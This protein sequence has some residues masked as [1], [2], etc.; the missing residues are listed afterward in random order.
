MAA[1][2]TPVGPGIEVTQAS[3]ALTSTPYAAA[4][5]A[6]SELYA[7]DI[8]AAR[9]GAE[10]HR[11]KSK[12]IAMRALATKARLKKDG[13]YA[14][15]QAASLKADDAA[16][17]KAK[18]LLAVEMKLD[19]VLKTRG[20]D[21][22]SEVSKSG[23]LLSPLSFSLQRYAVMVRRALKSS[24]PRITGLAD[25]NACAGDV[26]FERVLPR[27]FRAVIGEDTRDATAAIA[28]LQAQLR[29][30]SEFDAARFERTLV[31]VFERQF[32]GGR[33][34]GL[35]LAN[36]KQAAL[37]ESRVLEILA[38]L[39]ALCAD[40]NRP[41]AKY[42]T[43][44]S[45][46]MLWMNRFGPRLAAAADLRTSSL[47][48]LG[49]WMFDRKAGELRRITSEPIPGGKIQHFR[50]K[51]GH[52]HLRFRDGLVETSNPL[53]AFIR[54][55]L[56]PC[57]AAKRVVV[58]DKLVAVGFRCDPGCSGYD[59]KSEL[60][61]Q[62][63]ITNAVYSSDQAGC[64]GTEGVNGGVTG[65][66]DAGDPS[67]SRDGYLGQSSSCSS[68]ALNG[69]IADRGLL[70]SFA[71]C[72]MA[73]RPSMTGGIP[74]EPSGGKSCAPSVADGGAERDVPPGYE[75]EGEIELEDGRTVVFY[76]D[77]N[78]NVVAYEKDT[79]EKVFEG[80]G[81]D[82]S[83]TFGSDDPTP[84]TTDEEGNPVDV[85]ENGHTSEGQDHASHNHCQSAFG[86]AE[87]YSGYH[88]GTVTQEQLQWF[89]K[90]QRAS[91]VIQSCT[92]D[93]PDCGGCTTNDVVHECLAAET[94]KQQEA[95]KT[96]NGANPNPTG[97][98]VD[99]P[100]CDSLGLSSS[101]S[102]AIGALVACGGGAG[103]RRACPGQMF[104]SCTE[105]NPDCGCEKAPF[106]AL[107]PGLDPK[108]CFVDAC[109]GGPG[110]TGVLGTYTTSTGSKVLA[111]S[112]DT[113]S[114]STQTGCVVS[115]ETTAACW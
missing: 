89:M 69:L 31:D 85:D 112:V 11:L 17:A 29:C 74:A 67:G 32:D 114:S 62:D 84:A 9:D 64:E 8:A 108:Q 59:I 15:L 66:G 57:D 72:L 86:C 55:F 103:P 1:C 28:R 70:P 88:G 13:A 79:N 21:A 41:L 95:A 80:T 63:A 81:D 51:A 19:T 54:S 5:T 49:F 3:D 22:A 78:G 39:I 115:S 40:Y 87:G 75:E 98:E 37:F 90:V 93:N 16:A 24:R 56:L 7:L 109:D 14:S 61:K 101:A 107:P 92:Q 110:D 73:G 113:F 34:F 6:N 36:V 76:S 100:G 45:Q 50:G 43:Y 35:H 44:K 111:A 102:K 106:V 105:D 53:P 18:E 33:T 96:G 82:F 77:S 47:Y 99:G 42:A 52:K 48:R 2:A 65:T 94:A 46:G 25:S 104:A 12:A 20:A 27:Y 71:T 23:S 58:G 83:K 68:G 91:G 30:M 60:T 4:Q 10:W 26:V 38:P 97:C